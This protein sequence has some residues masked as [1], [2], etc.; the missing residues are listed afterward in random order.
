MRPAE[1]SSLSGTRF[2]SLRLI[3]RTHA[4]AEWQEVPGIAGDDDEVMRLL[5][6]MEPQ[7]TQNTQREATAY[8]ARTMRLISS[9]GLPKLSSRQRCRPVAFR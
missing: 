5:R 7:N 4:D 3:G 2:P 6:N 8:S 1:A 9:R